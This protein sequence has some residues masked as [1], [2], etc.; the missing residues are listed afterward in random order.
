MAEEKK[1]RGPGLMQKIRAALE[2]GQS[3]SLGDFPGASK[4]N[5]DGA[6]SSLRSV[7]YCGVGRSPL[8]IIRDPVTKAYRLWTPADGQGKA[9]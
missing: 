3:V 5:F 8:N 6:I 7:K 2:A 9:A 4:V 1:P